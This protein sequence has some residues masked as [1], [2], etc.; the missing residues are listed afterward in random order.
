MLTRHRARDWIPHEI[1][2]EGLAP[3]KTQLF[4]TNFKA[5][6]PKTYKATQLEATSQEKYTTKKPANKITKFY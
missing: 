5:E 6:D 1:D 4:D 3:E 2:K